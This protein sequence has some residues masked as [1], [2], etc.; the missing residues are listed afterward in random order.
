MKLLILKLVFSLLPYHIENVLQLIPSKKIAACVPSKNGVAVT[1]GMINFFNEDF[2]KKQFRGWESS[3]AEN[4]FKFTK[5][6][7]LKN[8]YEDQS[9][10]KLFIYR[11][12]VERVESAFK[13]KCLQNDFDYNKGCESIFGKKITSLNEAVNFIKTTKNA[14]DLD[15]HIHPQK[16]FCYNAFEHLDQFQYV[17]R[18]DQKNIKKNLYSFFSM[19]YPK[20]QIDKAWDAGEKFAGV[21][22]ITSTR[23]KKHFFNTEQIQFLEKFYEEDYRVFNILPAPKTDLLIPAMGRFDMVKRHMHS[24]WKFYFAPIIVVDDGKTDMSGEYAEFCRLKPCSYFW[25]G[26]NQGLSFKRNRLA[27]K[28]TS[29]YIFFADADIVWKKSSDLMYAIDVFNDGYDIV[30]MSYGKDWIGELSGTKTDILMKKNLVFPVNSYTKNC[31]RTD[32]ADNQFLT[33][34]QTML[35]NPLREELKMQEHM[36]FF[37]DAK[38]DSKLKVIQCKSLLLGHER[39]PDLA[40]R[41]ENARKANALVKRR[42]VEATE[43][44][45]STRI[46]VVLVS[47]YSTRERFHAV[48][49]TWAKDVVFPHTIAIVGDYKLCSLENKYGFPCFFS[50]FT[51][52][53]EIV[54][55]IALFFETQKNED[56]YSHFIKVDDDTF[57]LF[58]NLKKFIYQ[59]HNDTTV[60]GSAVGGTERYGG[61]FYPQ[62]GAGYLF[63][64][65]VLKKIIDSFVKIALNQSKYALEPSHAED[66]AFGLSLDWKKIDLKSFMQI[67]QIYTTLESFEKNHDKRFNKNMVTIHGLKS[68]KS[69]K[70][71][72]YDHVQ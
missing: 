71:F 50:A 37:Y 44:E 53:K 60:S 36:P 57:V 46:M 49:N 9:W 21:S 2:T 69:I 29:E 30:A 18:F 45:K 33:K 70:Q 14:E 61:L 56:V 17:L 68:A 58:Q 23:F 52:Y 67:F 12:P 64:K 10:T 11:D 39:T 26:F 59:Q 34:K 51:S 38:F 54:V 1:T 16:S 47:S 27:E 3:F 25:V 72:Y 20:S 13:S 40:L 32:I 6:E 7:I 35:R 62:G 48:M 19:F 43:R 41:D 24:F 15:R 65:S 63:H 55:K 28:S 66:V 22:H 5:N 31:V 4:N 8:I 42:V